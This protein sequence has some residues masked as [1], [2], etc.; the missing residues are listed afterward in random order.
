MTWIRPSPDPIVRSS[1]DLADKSWTSSPQAEVLSF[2]LADEFDLF[3][4]FDPFA[5]LW[6]G[7]LSTSRENQISTARVN[8]TW[9]QGRRPE[10]RSPPDPGGWP[11]GVTIRHNLELVNIST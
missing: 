5:M 4:K 1:L 2:T 7:K 8:R 11:F 10:I 6:A 3:N 9:P